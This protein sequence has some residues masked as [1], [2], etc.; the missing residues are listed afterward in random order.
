MNVPGCPDGVISGIIQDMLQQQNDMMAEWIRE[1][2]DEIL[3]SN[4]GTIAAILCN[5]GRQVI[6]LN[7]RHGENFTD[8]REP[9]TLAE[10]VSK[11]A[12]ERGFEWP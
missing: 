7:A 2:P 5:G 12:R 10:Y 11:L 4:E 1:A 3:L 9:G 6:L 8:F